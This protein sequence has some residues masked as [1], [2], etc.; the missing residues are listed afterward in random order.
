MKRRYQVLLAVTSFLAFIATLG[1]E[2]AIFTG[3]IAGSVLA[4]I[5]A[6][7]SLRFVVVKTMGY[8]GLAHPA[9]ESRWPRL[10]WRILQTLKKK[11]SEWFNKNIT[12]GKKSSGGFL[13]VLSVLLMFNRPGHFAYGRARVFGL[14]WIQTVSEEMERHFT[15]CGMTGSGKSNYTADLIANIP[16][17]ASIFSLD[18]KYFF[19]RTV[20]AS[21]RLRGQTVHTVA[22]LL[23]STASINPIQSVFE[24]NRILGEDLTEILVIGICKA[25]IP[26]EAYEKPFFNN[27]AGQIV[28]AMILHEMS[29]DPDTDLTVIAERAFAGYSAET[30]NLTDGQ[31]AYLVAMADN[32][33][34]NG[35]ISRIALAALSTDPKTLSNIMATATAPLLWL[36]TPQAKRFMVRNDCFLTDLKNP[37]RSVTINLACPPHEMRSTF[38]G[39]FRMMVYLVTKFME[40]TPNHGGEKTRIIFEEMSTIGAID[41]LPEIW[42]LL[43]GYEGLAVGV[44]TEI[45]SLRRNYPDHWQ[46][47]LGN[48]SAIAWLQANDNE[49]LNYIS[50]KLGDRTIKYRENGQVRRNDRPV[51]KPED[52]GRFLAYEKYKGGNVIVTRAGRRPLALRMREYFRDS[53]VFLYEADHEHSEPRGRA[54]GRSLVERF[55]AKRARLPEQESIQSD[56]SKL[57]ALMQGHGDTR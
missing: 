3:Q 26:K 51:L 39:Y 15:I 9:I 22:P 47:I 57:L 2:M 17:E 24:L 21:R 28:S 43:R 5:L 6:N 46:G 38:A 54:F 56:E 41:G 11:G 8:F 52:V 4:V 12:M 20:Y 36:L 27:K 30:E 53:P 45:Q 33:S 16:L 44:I 25:I 13:P 23:S 19:D 18:P 29:I 48:S 31:K 10:P 34:F 7:A 55:R 40:L 42:P 1:I 50:E 49:T 37:E 14:P 32:P 35:L